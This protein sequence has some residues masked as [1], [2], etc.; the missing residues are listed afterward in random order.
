M[1]PANALTAGADAMAGL[2]VAWSVAPDAVLATNLFLVPAAM[3]LYAGGVALNDLC[4]AALDS[5]ERPERP[6]PSGRVSWVAALGLAGFLMA[7]GV[8]LAALAA[9][10]AGLIA[11]AVAVLAISYDAW[12]KHRS[13]LGPLNM[14]LC[15]AGSL[16]LGVSASAAALAQWWWLGV[17]PL[18][19]VA[20]ITVVSRG[21]VS[22]RN[23]LGW[24]AAGLVAL[25]GGVLAAVGWAGAQ[26]PA[27]GFLVLFLALVLPPFVV[28]AA[29]P[30]PQS[31]RNAVKAGVTSIV[32]FDAALAAAFSGLLLGFAV[33]L[34]Y[35]LSR[36]LG[37]LFPVA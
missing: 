26:L 30:S 5:V 3:S 10:A 24:W 12:A 27:L 37:R 29:R 32:V 8:A 16:L 31:I 34:L 4:D 18:A 17:L 22:G 28:S 19:Y 20:A 35:P 25:V 14:G 13:V 11:A 36:A 2:A 7:L 9:P 21:E 33:L 23:A 15:R 6:I 1:R